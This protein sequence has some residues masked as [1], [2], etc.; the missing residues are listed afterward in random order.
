VLEA[1]KLPARVTGLDTSLADV[2]GD[3]LTHF[4]R[5]LVLVKGKKKVLKEDF[6]RTQNRL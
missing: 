3:A 4:E 6:E 2:D 1:V 5:V